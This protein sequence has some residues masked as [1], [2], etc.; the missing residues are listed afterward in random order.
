MISE[1]K[2]AEKAKD[3][4]L[5][6]NIENKYFTFTE[7]S[8]KTKAAQTDKNRN[9]VWLY[10]S[11]VEEQEIYTQA[12]LKKGYD[13][14]VFD[15]IIDPHFIGHLEMSVEKTQLKRVDADGLNKLIEKDEP[16]PDLLTED[17]K[18]KLKNIFEKATGQKAEQLAIEPLS[19]DSLPVL[20]TEAEFMRRMKEMSQT[21]GMGM[22][23]DMPGT[24]KIV[25]NSNHPSISKILD[26]EDGEKQEQLARYAYDLALLSNNKLKGKDLAAFIER[27]LTLMN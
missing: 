4:A 1:P 27:S 26:T 24:Q 2:F 13:V 21:N 10:T 9:T 3:F 8:E 6:K 17:Q 18:T 14:L 11:N 22:W 5:V 15:H 25:L 12:A 16:T 7:Y 23:G 19:S 20:I